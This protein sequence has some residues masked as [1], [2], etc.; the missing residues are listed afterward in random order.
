MR[1]VSTR[2]NTIHR[3]KKSKLKKDP[4]AVSLGKKGGKLGGPARARSLTGA[5]RSQIAKHSANKRWG[6]KTSYQKPAFYYRK[7]R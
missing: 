7:V 1:R 4:A 6:N 3:G 5:K 2:T